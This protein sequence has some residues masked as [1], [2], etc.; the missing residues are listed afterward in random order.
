MIRKTGAFC[1]IASRDEVGLRLDAFLVRH[2]DDLSR[3]EAARWVRH[4]LV[5]VNDSRQKPAYRVRLNDRISG[6]PPEP[7]VVN[8]EP[9]PID[10]DRRF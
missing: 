1:F 8:F 6:L 10:L 4:Q 7:E 9:E 2:L 5:Q 3:S